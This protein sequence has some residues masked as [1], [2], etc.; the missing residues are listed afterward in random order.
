MYRGRSV[1]VVM[2]VHN[3]QDHVESAVAHVPD[4]VDVIIVIDDGSTDGTW[5]RLVSIADPR[6]VR[7]RHDQNRGVGAATKSGYRYCL[8]TEC[9]LIAVM[10]GDGQMDGRDLPAL[11]DRAIEGA[12][13]VKGNRFL[14]TETIDAMPLARYIGNRVLS[15]LARWAAHFEES[16]D[17]QCGYSVIS[18]DALVQ[19]NLDELYDRYGFPDEMFFSAM[20]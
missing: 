16:L 7:L 19:L 5:Q 3:E 17:A 13:F 20:R 2:P 8:R 12:A 14:H 6:L 10:D 11:L 4:F 1:A 18:R 15:H 9:D